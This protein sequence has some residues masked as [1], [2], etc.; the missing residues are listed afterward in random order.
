MSHR[1]LSNSFH[2]RRQVL[3]SADGIDANDQTDRSVGSLCLDQRSELGVSSFRYRHELFD[4][5]F[6]VEWM[7][8]NDEEP[9]RTITE[10][11]HIEHESLPD[12]HQITSKSSRSVI[13]VR[14]IYQNNTRLPAHIWRSLAKVSFNHRAKI[15]SIRCSFA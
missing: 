9:T 2:R 14:S 3:R 10:E 8:E 5:G 6:G 7:D 15:S 1:S 11:S 4:H 13:A 12:T